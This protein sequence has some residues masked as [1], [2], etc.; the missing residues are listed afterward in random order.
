MSD[1]QRK[2]H[3]ILGVI[4]PYCTNTDDSV[5]SLLVH[6]CKVGRVAALTDAAD[7]FV[8]LNICLT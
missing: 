1:S 6:H 8:L 7:V 3:K 4:I 2:P 5:H